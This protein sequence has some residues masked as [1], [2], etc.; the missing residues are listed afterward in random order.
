[1]ELINIKVKL[2]ILTKRKTIKKSELVLKKLN[3][4]DKPVESPNKKKY[5]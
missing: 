4:R 2:M 5:K 1:M 3:A